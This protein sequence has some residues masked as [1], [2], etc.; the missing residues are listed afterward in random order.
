MKVE[1]IAVGDELLLGQTIDTNSGWIA[2]RLA[3][4]GIKVLRMSTIADEEKPM[5]EAFQKAFQRSEVCLITGGLGPTHDDLTK[6]ILADFFDLPLVFR[7]D[8][9]DQVRDLYR[10][11]QMKFIE[12]SREQAEFPQGATPMRNAHGTAPGIWIERE[13]HVFA[14]MP[15]VPAEMKGMMNNFVMPRLVKKI[16]GKR[17]FFRTLHAAG[18]KEAELYERLTNR[19]EILKV[20]RIAFLPSHVG[21][22]LR[23]TVE[24]DREDEA[25]QRLDKAEAM[26]REKV[27]EFVIGTG[28][29]FTTEHAVGELLKDKRMMLAVAESCTGGLIGKRLTDVP[30]ASQ[31]FERGF[32]TYTND[33]KHE[34]LGVPYELLEQHGAVSAPVAE[35]MA[36]GALRNSRAQ[37]AV[38]VTGIAGP[39]G[40]TEEKPVGLTYI[41][42]ADRTVTT[43]REHRFGDDREVNRNRSALAVMTLI[44]DQ[45]KPQAKPRDGQL[46]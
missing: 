33:A 13:G 22:R 28:E 45:L 21:L 31:W 6:P 41:G 4:E 38:S 15:G 27:G 44:L 16:H 32:I 24:T 25:N 26:L 3:R 42:Y 40:G 34:L 7:N 20:V 12:T 37:V 18:I 19:E 11:R 30:G 10:R 5:R 14:A 23:L 36:Q 46:L 39:T 17:L 9:L 8:I 29:D 1:I 2:S 35:A 43:S